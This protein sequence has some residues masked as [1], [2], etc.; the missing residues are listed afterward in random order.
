MTR[1]QPPLLDHK[2]TRPRPSFLLLLGYIPRRRTQDLR[3]QAIRVSI[4]NDIDATAASGRNHRVLESQ[5][6]AHDARHADQLRNL[7]KM[8]LK[9]KSADCRCC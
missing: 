8:A 7:K 9:R 3:I 6:N 5:V 1:N 4:Q 2:M